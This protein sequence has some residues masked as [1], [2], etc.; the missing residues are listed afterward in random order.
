MGGRSDEPTNLGPIKQSALVGNIHLNRSEGKRSQEVILAIR[1]SIPDFD[2]PPP[3]MQS[4]RRNERDTR[5]QGYII[6]LVLL[7]FVEHP[8]DRVV[9]D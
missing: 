5:P 7:P 8:R 4:N 6:Q 3:P 1:V 2:L 9:V